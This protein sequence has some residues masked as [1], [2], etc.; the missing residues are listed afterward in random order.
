MLRTWRLNDVGQTPGF[1][2]DHKRALGAI[3]AKATVIAGQTD[4]YF[5]PEDVEA[6]ASY[7]PGARFRVI[8]S[9][10]GHMAGAGI[11]AEDSQFIEAE[12]EALLAS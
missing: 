11:N 5:V 1:G 3:K 10:W 8:P 12:I 6:D 2:D 9:Q 7:I 4:L